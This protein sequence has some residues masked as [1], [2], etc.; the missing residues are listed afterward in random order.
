MKFHDKL[1]N[2]TEAG[3]TE[4]ALRE[5]LADWYREDTWILPV[6]T[7]DGTEMQAV[8]AE[9]VFTSSK[10]NGYRVIGADL[11][12][13]AILGLWAKKQGSSAINDKY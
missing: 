6:W 13:L 11:I 4:T 3:C 7:P 12:E 10:P 5:L 2:K 1:M 9:R 8:L